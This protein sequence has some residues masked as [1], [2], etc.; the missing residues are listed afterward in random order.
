MNFSLNFLMDFTGPH[1]FIFLNNL[2]YEYDDS[3][4]TTVLNSYHKCIYVLCKNTVCFSASQI[5]INTLQHDTQICGLLMYY[6]NVIFVCVQCDSQD[7]CSTAGRFP[8]FPGGA[9]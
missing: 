6:Y 1:F 2:V 7:E 8:G 9:G 3:E 5:I 4:L